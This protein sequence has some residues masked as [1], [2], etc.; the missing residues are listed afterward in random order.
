MKQ[1]LSLVVDYTSLSLSDVRQAMH[2][3]NQLIYARREYSASATCKPWT[4]V[5]HGSNKPHVL[6]VRIS[7]RCHTTLKRHETM[8][9]P[10]SRPSR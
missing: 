2:M 1:G 4:T 9:T 10:S 8:K 7:I 6:R 5:E 3:F